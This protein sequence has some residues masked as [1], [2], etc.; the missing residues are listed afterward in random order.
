MVWFGISFYECI[1]L[2]ISILWQIWKIRNEFQFS[3]IRKNPMLQFSK[4][5]ND[6]NE[7]QESQTADGKQKDLGEAGDEDKRRIPPRGNCIRINTD[8]T[9]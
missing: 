1:A 9:L 3:N 6:W 8:A 2:T 5:L 7:Y 4:S